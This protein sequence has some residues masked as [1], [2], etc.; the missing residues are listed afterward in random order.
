MGYLDLRASTSL[1]AV[2]GGL[3]LLVGFGG[4]FYGS[5]SQCEAT[6]D[7][8]DGEQCVDGTC[9]SAV[10]DDTGNRDAPSADDTYGPETEDGSG[11]GDDDTSSV[12]TSSPPDADTNLDCLERLADAGNYVDAETIRTIIADDDG[13]CGKYGAAEFEELDCEI[14]EKYQQEETEC[15][16]EIDNDC[17]G[18]L[19]C[20]DGSCGEHEACVEKAELGAECTPD[21]GCQ[22]GTCVK[23]SENQSRCVHIVGLTVQKFTGGFTGGASTS[24][25]LR[26]VDDACR[27]A[28]LEH[29]PNTDPS[30]WK[31]IVS[32]NQSD[33]GQ[34]IHAKSRLSIRAPLYNPAHEQ[35]AAG[36]GELAMDLRNPIEHTLARDPAE[37]GAFV[38]TGTTNGGELRIDENDT[39][40]LTCANWSKD[41]PTGG[42]GSPSATDGKWLEADSRNCSTEGYLYCINGQKPTN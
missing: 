34:P 9:Q 10:P 8:F 14:P 21:I 5:P 2:F 28:A 29:A 38:W 13:I 31:A 19:D 40:P 35:V 16:D 12:D 33:G 1:C 39:T 20:D 23:T 27:E 36:E 41:D 17:D 32:G 22:L 18:D 6:S 11:G 15:G 24:E 30:E 26:A 37:D 4:C 42:S 3:L 25:P 7:C